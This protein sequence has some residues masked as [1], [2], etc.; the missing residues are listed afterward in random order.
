MPEALI[1]DCPSGLEMFLQERSRLL[2]SFLGTSGPARLDWKLDSLG[3][4]YFLEINLTPGLSPFYSTFPI[5]YRWSLGDEKNLLQEILKIARLDFE[6]DRFLYA[7]K[8]I[9]S[10]SSQR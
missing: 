6:T 3:N 7:K 10:L 2:C 1:F 5:C 8:K 4:P 9:R